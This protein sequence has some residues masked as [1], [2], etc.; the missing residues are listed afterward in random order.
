MTQNI[1]EKVLKEVFSQIKAINRGLDESN[2][3][4]REMLEETI[5]L[6]LAEVG[7]VNEEFIKKLKEKWIWRMVDDELKKVIVI[8]DIDKLAKENK[9]KLGIK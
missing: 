7:K 6:T 3:T 9:Q 8:E 1:K 5:D 2:V 4:Y